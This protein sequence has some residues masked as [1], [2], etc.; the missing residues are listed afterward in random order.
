MSNLSVSNL[1]VSIGIAF[2]SQLKAADN[3]FFASAVDFSDATRPLFVGSVGDASGQAVKLYPNDGSGTSTNPSGY[4]STN[5]AVSGDPGTVRQITTADGPRFQITDN[6]GREVKVET[7]ASQGNYRNVPRYIVK[8]D[9]IVYDVLAPVN[10]AGTGNYGIVD[11]SVVPIG[12]KGI[13]GSSY[14]AAPAS[15]AITL[16]HYSRAVGRITFKAK[17]GATLARAQDD[18]QRT[19]SIVQ[20]LTRLLESIQ[21]ESKGFSSLI[22]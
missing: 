22:R 7:Q 11:T 17:E 21:D 16:Q 13:Q 2:D 18:L 19:G 14:A 3:L 20:L 1:I 4:A 5:N 9:G 6:N 15:N 8:A 12:S 10:A